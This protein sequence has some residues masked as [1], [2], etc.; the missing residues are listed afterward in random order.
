M[1]KL[2]FNILCSFGF[3]VWSVILTI[4]TGRIPTVNCYIFTNNLEDTGPFVICSHYHKQIHS[5]KNVS[6]SC[7]VNIIGDYITSLEKDREFIEFIDK[8][9]DIPMNK[10]INKLCELNKIL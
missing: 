7:K 4:I 8:S 9:T 3:A 2:L 6:D 1:F 5:K 10:V